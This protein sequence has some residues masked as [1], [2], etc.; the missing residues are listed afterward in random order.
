MKRPDAR[1][2][3]RLALLAGVAVSAL[4]GLAAPCHAADAD[5]FNGSRA[6]SY[7]QRLVNFGPR[8]AGSKALGKARRWIIGQLQKSGWTVEQDAFTADTPIG[9]IPMVNLIAKLPGTSRKVVML[10][11]HYDTKRFSNF[12]FVGA[13]D[14]G[15]SA[16]LLLEMARILPRQKHR[17]TYWLVFFDGEEA[18]QHWS[19]TDGVYGSRQLVARLTADGTLDRIQAMILVDMIA[20]GHLDIHPDANSTSWLNKLVFGTADR[21][22]YKQYFRSDP[23]AV[24]DDHIP[25]INAGVSAI[26]LI[27]L[28]YGPG[29]DPF[30][31]YWHTAQDTVQHCSPASLAIVGRV[32]RATLEQLEQTP[33]LP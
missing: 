7:L 10:A 12:R 18:I 13:N 2:H 14:G 3:L 1:R 29:K 6:F 28:D 31:G 33:R 24:E 22:G 27:G 9:S 23:T 26:D 19:N 17:F 16:A 15:S 32:V 11:G 30:G 5:A 8:P 20:G 21:L 25:F 4:A